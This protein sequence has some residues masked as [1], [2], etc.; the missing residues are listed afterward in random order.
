M[1]EHEGI[2]LVIGLKYIATSLYRLG[3]ITFL[4]LESIYT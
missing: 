3:P 1:K 2:H 4:E